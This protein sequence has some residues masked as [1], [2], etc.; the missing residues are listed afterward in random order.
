MN[1]SEYVPYK[2]VTLEKLTY[3]LNLK[4]YREVDK[5][6][7]ENYIVY[8]VRGYVWSQDAGKKVSFKYPAGWWQAFKERWFRGWLLRRYPVIYTH[9]EFQ[10][11][12]TYPDL[13]VQHNEPVLRLLETTYTDGFWK[14][15]TEKRE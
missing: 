13:I 11:K 4:V 15:F 3:G 6:Y 1:P 7:T 5:D 10:V 9:K 12:A 8:Q 14:A 2:T